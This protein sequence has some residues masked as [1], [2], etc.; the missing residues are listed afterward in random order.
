MSRIHPRAARRRLCSPG[1]GALLCS[2]LVGLAQAQP[3]TTP[4][5]S[6]PASAAAAA[7]T[8]APAAAAARTP[9]KLPDLRDLGL[10][11]PR[12]VKA[13]SALLGMGRQRLAL[14]VGIGT[15]G[16]RSVVDSASRDSQAVAAALREGGFV[17]M[18]R[19]DLNGADLRAVLKEFHDRLQPG[20]LGFVYVAGLGVQLDGQNL[21]L[22]RD[23]VLDAGSAPAERQAQLLRAAVPLS[24]LVDALMGPSDSPRLLVVD[25]AYRHPA[26]IGLP[27]AGL[28][29]LK[30]PPGMMAL[31]GHGLGVWQDVPAAAPLPSPP[32]SDAR[33]VAAT[34]F[35]RTLVAELLSPRKRAPEVLRATRRKLVDASL[36]VNEPWMAGDTEPEELAEATLLDGLVPQTPEEVAREVASRAG[37]AMLRN[38]ASSAGSSALASAGEQSVTSVLDEA[39]KAPARKIATSTVGDELVRNDVPGSESRMRPTSANGSLADAPSLPKELPNVPNVP[40]A[41]SSALSSAGSALGTAGSALGTA[42]S[43]VGT[44]ASVA[45]TAATVAVVAKAAELSAATSVASTAVSAAGSVA[46]QA[47]AMAARAFS[48]SE[49]PAAAA[50]TQQ[51]ATRLA[52][53]LAAAAATQTAANVASEAARSAQAASADVPPPAPASA[54]ATAAARAQATAGANAAEQVTNQGGANAASA[55]SG[56]E[57]AVSAVNTPAE[58]ARTAA[59]QAQAAPSPGTASPLQ[60][61]PNGLKPQAQASVDGRTVRNANGGERPAYTPRTN[62]YGYAEGDTYTYQV[63]DTWKDEVMGN[64]TTA[65]EEVLDN[66]QMLAD[67]QQT[68][69]DAMGR[70]VRQPHPDGSVSQFEPAQQLWWSNPKRGESRDLK[71]KEVIQRGKNSVEVEWKGSTSVGRPRKIE[72]PAGEYEVLPMESSGW[73]YEALSDGLRST[74]WTRTVWYSPKLGHPVAIDIE[75]ADRLGKVLKRERVEL[76]HAQSARTAQ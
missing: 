70:L 53:Q 36:G 2:L 59:R 45:G 71:F 73:Y 65:I 16:T 32:P 23:T 63:I 49:P 54:K 39:A 9:L 4:P 75:E 17:V 61:G 57:L 31:Y 3:A 20:G 40:S 10:D 46:G 60:G 50:A 51:A 67:G 33:E 7:T 42:A 38:G 19:E 27:N 1:P 11:V 18:L 24:E 66:G 26:L 12:P 56:Q 15:V 34:P 68:V 25:A 64:Y 14:V 29:A 52:P 5:A 22:P 72:T 58:V 48:G 76:L 43:V 41:S 35:A 69:M 28:A 55:T 8:E 47:V 74:K 62:P 6:P 13:A 30:V 44:A 37:R 21:L